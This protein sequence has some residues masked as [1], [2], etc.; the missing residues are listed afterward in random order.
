[1]GAVMVSSLFQKFRRTIQEAFRMKRKKIKR[2]RRV[3]SRVVDKGL[4]SR[5]VIFS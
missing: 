1:M 3:W 4:A 2:G 5:M